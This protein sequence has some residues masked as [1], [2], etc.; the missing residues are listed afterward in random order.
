MLNISRRKSLLTLTALSLRAPLSAKTKQTPNP[1]QA[2]W[3]L[4]Q[5]RDAAKQAAKLISEETGEPPHPAAGE[6]MRFHANLSLIDSPA[7]DAKAAQGHLLLVFFWASW[8]PICKALAPKLQRFW[9]ANRR[10]GLQLL[11][12]SADKDPQVTRA[13]AKKLGFHFPIAM[14]SSLPLDP[15]FQ[16]R[17]FPTLM[18]RSKRGAVVSVEEGDLSSAELEELLIHL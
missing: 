10:Q 5:E 4:E 12:I 17:S 3:T 11:S 6:L 8:C 1:R 15:V 9:Q 7:W 13:T 14:A 2:T 18:V 16:T